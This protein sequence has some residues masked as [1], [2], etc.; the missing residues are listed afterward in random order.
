MAAAVTFQAPKRLTSTIARARSSGGAPADAGPPM[1][2]LF[3]STSR[4]P[5]P[6]HRLRHAR[7][8]AARR[9][10]VA[11]DDVVATPRGRGRRRSRRG[12]AAPRR[13]RCRR[14][15]RAGDQ[16]PRH[17]GAG[18]PAG[19]RRLHPAPR[20]PAPALVLHRQLAHEPVELHPQVRALVLAVALGGGVAAALRRRARRLAA[21]RQRV[22]A[23]EV[24]GEQ[25]ATGAPPPGIAEPVVCTRP[26]KNRSSSSWWNIRLNSGSS[27]GGRAEQ[28]TGSTYG[29]VTR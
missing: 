4:P 1:P 28:P 16:H 14:R 10:D 5:Q 9:G 23:G 22:A 3:T 27:S 21:R 7:G 13:R 12:R 6:L 25:L 8:T 17:A 24:V 29:T 20:P 26:M 19:Q 15:R 18:S 2:A 11:G